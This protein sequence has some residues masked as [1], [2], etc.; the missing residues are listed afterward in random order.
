[1]KVIYKSIE[2]MIRQAIYAADLA[3]R[4][5]E[6]IELSVAEANEIAEIFRKSFCL[7]ADRLFPYAAIDAG[8]EIGQL[9]GVRLVIA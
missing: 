9:Y 4:T 2:V 3:N 7:P 8:K 5:I 6:K 1:M